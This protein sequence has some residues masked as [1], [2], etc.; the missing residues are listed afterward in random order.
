[1]CLGELRPSSTAAITPLH[2]PLL[3]ANASSIEVLRPS[4]VDRA[5]RNAR[6][7]SSPTPPACYSPAPGV[8]VMDE[9]LRSTAADAWVPLPAPCE[10]SNTDGA[11]AGCPSWSAAHHCYG[12]S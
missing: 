6:H 8:E 12:D 7:R 3:A 5:P 4:Y 2:F 11:D 1:M 9:E 10:A